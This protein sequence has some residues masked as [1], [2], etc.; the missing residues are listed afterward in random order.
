[1]TRPAT[2]RHSPMGEVLDLGQRSLDAA[3]YFAG[4]GFTDLGSMTG[5]IEAWSLQVD[6]SV[7]RYELAPDTLGG[8][9]LRPLRSAVSPAEGCQSA[10]AS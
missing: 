8:A 9:T 10:V 7:P 3:S 5:G 4:H 6:P 1:M 2:T